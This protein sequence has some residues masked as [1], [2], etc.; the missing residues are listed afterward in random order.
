VAL[1][2]VLQERLIAGH[3]WMNDVASKQ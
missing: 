2:D 1:R 3:T